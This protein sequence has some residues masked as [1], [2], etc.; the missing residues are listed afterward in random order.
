MDLSEEEM[1][2]LLKAS[3]KDGCPI[4][5]ARLIIQLGQ[6]EVALG[7]IPRS[8]EYHED[9]VYKV[10]NRAFIN[11]NETISE[12]HTEMIFAKIVKGLSLEGYATT[13]IVEFIN[14]RI[15]YQNGPIYCDES[16]VSEA[17]R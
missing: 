15:H 9:L 2:R 10:G 8:T 13:Q 6:L 3:A 16:E 17:I 11:E 4:W 1:V 5:A 7:N 14:S 12:R